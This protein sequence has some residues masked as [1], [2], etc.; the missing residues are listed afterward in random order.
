MTYAP[1]ARVLV[2]PLI[3]GPARKALILSKVSDLDAYEVRMTDG[4][5]ATVAGSQLAPAANTRKV[6][7]A[8]A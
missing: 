2:T 7:D 3:P 8:R 6:I 1:R 5:R 4:S